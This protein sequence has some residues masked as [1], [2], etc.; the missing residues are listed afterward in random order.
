VIGMEMRRRQALGAL[1]GA[2]LVGCDA[3]T[4]PRPTVAPNTRPRIVRAVATREGQGA[5][6]H[7]L[8]PQRGSDHHDPF[9][10]LDDFRVAPPAGFPEHPHRGFE[11]FTYMIEGS[12]E[13]RDDM[14][15]ESV[16]TTHGT[17]RFTSGRGARHSE[18]PGESRIN[19]GLQLWVNLPRAEKQIPPDYAAV[20]GH[21]LP[22]VSVRGAVQRTIVGSGSPVAL[23]TPVRYLDLRV[24]AGVAFEEEVP[25]GWQGMIYVADGHARIGDVELTAGDAALLAAAA[26]EVRALDDARL[27]VLAG[28][29][30]G[31]PIVQ[32]GPFVD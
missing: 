8:F 30:H 21:D 27:F 10:L 15:N 16:V 25:S 18:M 9:V 6:V 28:R 2:V 24:P 29:S 32:R 11:A 31:E 14:G 26:F 1:A 7:R 4:P 22:E 3:S 5:R 12:F 19:R 23:R 13:H 17:Q 20:H